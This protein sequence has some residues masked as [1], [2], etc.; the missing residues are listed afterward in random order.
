M[1][2]KY[3]FL[4]KESL[5]KKVCT[6]SFKIVNIILFIIIIGLLNIDTII[7]SFGGDFDESVNIY[8]VDECNVYDELESLF[9]SNYLDLMDSDTKLVKSDKSLNELKETIKNDETNDIIIDIKNDNEKVFNIDIIS[10][11]Y[12]DQLMYQSLVNVLNT[13]KVNEA[14]KRSNISTSELQKIYESVNINR[15]ILNEEL[16]ENSELIEQIGGVVSIIF[17]MPFFMLIVLIVQM[18]GAEINEEKRTKS[19][20]VI[21]SSVPAKTHF[22]SK[23]TA[24]NLFAIIQG[25]LLILYVIIGFIVKVLV[26]G[27]PDLSSASAV[28]TAVDAGT[29]NSY[30]NVFVNSEVFS[31]ILIGIPLFIIIILLSFFA[32]SLFIG[33]LAS[34]TTSMEDYNQI[35]TPVMLFLVA[36]Y[37]LAISASVFQGASFIKF[38]AFVPFIS[39]ILAPVVY[40]LGQM[41]L[42]EFIISILILAVTCYYFYKYGLKVYKEGI[43][44][45]QSSNLWKKIFRSLK[46]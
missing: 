29:L 43:L 34:V 2:S 15:I 28:G 4:T 33:V 44:N 1:K 12:V 20:E 35:Q 31:K 30:I 21:I 23:L 45:Y 22:L 32:Y 11:D 18:I 40:S 25:G 10:Y 41:S 3:W 42:I 13:V 38:A 36:G 8:V 26:S 5:K 14:I 24:A 6:K 7:K 9:K 37:Y 19:M 27:M 16:D 46:N 17:V 39:G